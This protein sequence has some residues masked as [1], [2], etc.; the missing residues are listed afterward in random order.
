MVPMFLAAASGRGHGLTR[1]AATPRRQRSLAFCC[2]SAVAPSAA[3]AMEASI[4][5]ATEGA[6]LNICYPSATEGATLISWV[7][8]GNI[9]VLG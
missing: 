4:S 1:M 6:T 2:N 8:P 7:I 9:M 5:S 3:E